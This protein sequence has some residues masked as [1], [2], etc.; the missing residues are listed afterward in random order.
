MSPVEFQGEESIE[1]VLFAKCKVKTMKHSNQ[2]FYHENGFPIHSMNFILNYFF[3][4][5]L[6][7]MESYNCGRNEKRCYSKNGNGR[8]ARTKDATFTWASIKIR[9]FFENFWLIRKKCKGNLT[10]DTLFAKIS[11]KMC[12]NFQKRIFQEETR[13][14][15]TNWISCKNCLICSNY[16]GIWD[17]HNYSAACAV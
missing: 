12:Q 1:D 7:L 5:L 17:L 8:L 14:R 10:S 15:D 4:K 3:T 2:T 16:I 9:E 13:E 11:F 6:F